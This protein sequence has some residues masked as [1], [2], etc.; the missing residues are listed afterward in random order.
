MTLISFNKLFTSLLIC[1]DILANEKDREEICVWISASFKTLS[2][3]ESAGEIWW[4]IFIMFTVS[5]SGTGG[6]L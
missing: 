3:A 4:N 1:N 5:E 2:W 6:V